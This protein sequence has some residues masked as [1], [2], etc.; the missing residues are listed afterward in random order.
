MFL[1]DGG[2]SQVAFEATATDFERRRDEIFAVAGTRNAHESRFEM[3]FDEGIAD[4]M[5]MA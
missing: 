1:C 2:V 4:R 3:G 5:A